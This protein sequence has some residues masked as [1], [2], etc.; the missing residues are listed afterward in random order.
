M[1]SEDT[2][3]SPDAVAVEGEAECVGEETDFC[4]AATCLVTVGS[5][6]EAPKIFIGMASII[7]FGTVK[8]FMPKDSKSI[9]PA[10]IRRRKS[11]LARY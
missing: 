7:S 4:S 9:S 3:F 8:R 2:L 5:I 10:A 11:R 1:L 6:D